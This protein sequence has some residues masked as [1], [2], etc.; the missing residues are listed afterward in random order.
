MYYYHFIADTPYCGTEYHELLE[1]KQLM[2][3][4]EI[5]EY[6]EDVRIQNAECYSYLETGWEDDWESEEQAEEYFSNCSCYCEEITDPDRW[7]E[8]KEEYA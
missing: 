7:E 8:L 4:K 5:K 2:T 1:T 3:Q 6:C